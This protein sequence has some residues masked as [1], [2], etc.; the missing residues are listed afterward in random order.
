MYK[1]IKTFYQVRNR[2]YHQ[3]YHTAQNHITTIQ[4]FN[5][6]YLQK[7]NK[8][9]TITYKLDSI[10]TQNEQLKGHLIKHKNNYLF[11]NSV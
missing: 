3:H 6:K 11:L 2:I 4:L 7:Q 5:R 10:S 1:Q 8:V 9:T